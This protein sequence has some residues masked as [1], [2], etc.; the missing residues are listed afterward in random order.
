MRKQPLSAQLSD[1]GWARR[2]RE[3]RE[4]AERCQTPAQRAITATVMSRALSGKASGF[5]LTGSTVRGRRTAISDLDY[6]V[7]GRRPDVS[8][9]PGEVDVV[10]TGAARFRKRLIDGED[11][12]QW[13][14]RYGC[15]LHDAPPLREG[16][17]LIVERDLWPD[18]QRKLAAVPAHRAELER[19][20]EMGDQSAAQD[21]LRA[22]LTTA[23]RGVLLA[24]RVFPLAR[25][26][27]PA[28]LERVGQADLAAALRRAIC[29]ALSLDEAEAGLQSLDRSLREMDVGAP[30]A[31]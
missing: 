18:A 12:V 31:A 5:A 20:I 8:D 16:L 25:A 13:T 14:L 6:H 26:E 3:D 4:R 11:F 2:L 21:Q 9:L 19:L 29:E 10:A 23:A 28:Q 27:L 1:A 17:R 24:A 22:T 7:I 30:V 15:I